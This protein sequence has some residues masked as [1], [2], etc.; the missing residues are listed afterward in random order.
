MRQFATLKGLV[1]ALTLLTVG[2]GAESACRPAKF[3]V[4]AREMSLSVREWGLLPMPLGVQ[5]RLLTQA[6]HS[7]SGRPL[8]CLCQR[9]KAGFSEH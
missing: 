4:I 1:S 3:L 9:K 7:L 8:D 2:A 5:D 6:R